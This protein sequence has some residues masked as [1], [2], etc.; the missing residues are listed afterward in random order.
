ME[1]FRS[2]LGVD[3]GSDKIDDSIDISL[4]SDGFFDFE[5]AGDEKA[6]MKE[7][8]APPAKTQEEIDFDDFDF[9]V[10]ELEALQEDLRPPFQSS[11]SFERVKIVSVVE[12][13]YEKDSRKFQF[14]QKVNFEKF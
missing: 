2:Q 4:L 1:K 8:D 7:E 3:H 14:P 9:D 12:S 5:P 6:P 11:R 10:D 13:S